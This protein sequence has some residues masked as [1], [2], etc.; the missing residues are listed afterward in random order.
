MDRSCSAANF[1]C[2]SCCACRQM[3]APRGP[4]P[5]R[6]AM[7]AANTNR[8]RKR[9]SVRS[10][11]PTKPPPPP[12]KLRWRTMPLWRP[13]DR[14]P[15][16]SQAPLSRRRL[17]MALG[18]RRR[19]MRR[20]CCGESRW[21]TRTA[22]QTATRRFRR[23]MLSAAGLRQAPTCCGWCSGIRPMGRPL[24][25][26]APRQQL[27]ALQRAAVLLSV[28]LQMNS[29]Q[30]SHQLGSGSRSGSASLVS[31]LRTAVLRMPRRRRRCRATARQ[32]AAPSRTIGSPG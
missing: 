25:P 1:R 29:H 30:S 17:A 16:D 31:R 23:V 8:A 19:Q 27:P 6:Q 14:A 11:R 26:A 15:L 22:A 13:H 28:K 12:P 2:D 24:L 18:P 9:R 5:Q 7:R 4:R 3:S 20:R 21:P 32:A 10:R